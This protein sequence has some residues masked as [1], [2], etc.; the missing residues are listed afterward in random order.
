MPKVL[1]LFQNIEQ[2]GTLPYSLYKASTSLI[3]KQDK[4]TTGKENQSSISD[5]YRFKSSQYSIRK[6]N[7]I[8]F[9]MIDHIP[10]SNRIHPRDARMFRHTQSIKVIKHINKLKSKNHMIISMDA[11]NTATKTQYEFVIKKTLNKVDIEGTRK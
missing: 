3:R 6:L 11:E 1:E 7:S 10:L 9:K 8:A 4:A 2:E 5:K